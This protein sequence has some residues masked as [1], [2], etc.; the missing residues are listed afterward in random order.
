MPAKAGIHI[1]RHV[2]MDTGFRR[3]DIQEGP[4]IPVAINTLVLG[5]AEH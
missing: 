3:Y 2:V 1:H 5:I 4:A